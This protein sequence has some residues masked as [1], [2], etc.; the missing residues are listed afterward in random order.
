MAS[1]TNLPGINSPHLTPEHEPIALTVVS[2]TDTI[3]I[4]WF[5]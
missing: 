4:F 2:G 3:V 1:A 5:F